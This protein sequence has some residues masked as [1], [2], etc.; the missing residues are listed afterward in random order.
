MLLD[1]INALIARK[2]FYHHF[3]PLYDLTSWNRIGLEVLFRSALFENP[4]I[5]FEKA[6]YLNKLI[7][8]EKTSIHKAISS[9]NQT[10][11]HKAHEKLFI[12]AYPSTLCHSSF[13][14]F[15]NNVLSASILK[16]EQIVFEVNE[17]EVVNDINTFKHRLSELKKQGFLIAIDDVGKGMSSLRTIVEIEPHFV[18]MDNYFSKNLS[19]SVSKQEMIKSVLTYCKHTNIQFILEGIEEEKDLA[20]AK[21]LGVCIGQGYLLGKP[22][23]LH[24]AI[25]E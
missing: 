16:N 17:K 1:K 12:N 24:S 23:L 8:L 5:A 2:Q 13:I 20:V 15:I 25:S 6:R 7:V 14:N 9:Y 10:E 4:E 22:S 18:K 21:A 11:S 19:D 3:Q